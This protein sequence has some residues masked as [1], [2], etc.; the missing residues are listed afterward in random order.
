MK[1]LAIKLATYL[2]KHHF[3]TVL[4]FVTQCVR[5]LLNYDEGGWQGG[6]HIH[7]VRFHIYLPSLHL[8]LMAD[9]VGKSWLILYYNSKVI[10]TE[11]VTILRDFPF[12]DINLYLP[13]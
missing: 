5:A 8:L 7:R 11:V 12:L 4:E 9:S 13:K 2:Y 6:K 3:G 10:K 1:K